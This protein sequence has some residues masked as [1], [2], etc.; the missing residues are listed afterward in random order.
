METNK[1][2]LYGF[3]YNPMIEESSA[4]LES[5]HKT[6]QGAELAMEKHKT[7]EFIKWDKYTKMRE[8]KMTN[9]ELAKELRKACPFGQFQDWFIQAIE[10]Q[11]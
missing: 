11:E 2:V 6:K 10:V 7:A 3:F 9:K 1:L 4:R 8:D 5:I